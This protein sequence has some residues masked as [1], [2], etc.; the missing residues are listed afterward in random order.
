MVLNNERYEQSLERFKDGIPCPDDFSFPSVVDK[1]AKEDANLVAIHWVASDF[2]SELKARLFISSSLP[3]CRK[4][5]YPAF[6]LVYFLLLLEDWSSS[7]EVSWTIALTRHT[8]HYC[9]GSDQ[10]DYVHTTRG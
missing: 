8:D 7:D 3:T 9:R 2:T 10:T 5:V 4:P 6:F 1:W